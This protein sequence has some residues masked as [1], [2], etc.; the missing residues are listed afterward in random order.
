VQKPPF[1]RGN[2][3]LL[4]K[5]WFASAI[6]QLVDGPGFETLAAAVSKP[7]CFRRVSRV[8]GLTEQ[9]RI[10]PAKVAPRTRGKEAAHAD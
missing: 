1:G 3:L 5:R 7:V 9:L 10:R 8:N 2:R 6:K 4:Q